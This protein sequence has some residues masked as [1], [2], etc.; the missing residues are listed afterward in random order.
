MPLAASSSGGSNYL[1]F[2]FII[3]LFGALYFLF[4]RPQQRRNREV[5][6][7]QS[8]L[9]VGDEV[10]TGSGVYGTVAEVDEEAGT[11]S[12][13]VSP[14]VIIKFARG[15]VARTVT[16]APQEEAE[17]EADEEYEYETDEADETHE[18][19]EV[20]ETHETDDKVTERKD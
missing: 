9:G 17:A 1:P 3:L 5:Q 15:A 8:R 16:P 4:I 18:A 10:M 7:M 20:E 14:E 2:V 19:D 13:E 12:L 6:A 11:V